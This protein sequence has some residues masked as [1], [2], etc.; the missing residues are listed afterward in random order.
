MCGEEKGS[1]DLARGKRLHV[2]VAIVYNKGV[3]LCESYDKMNGKFFASFIRQHFN[4]CFWRA[5]PQRDGKRLFVMDSD[6]SQTSKVAKNA[7]KDIE[8]ELLRIPRSSPDINPIENIFHIVKNLLE[9]E[10]IEENLT[11]ET[12]EEFK[13]RVLR[14]IKNVDPAIIDK[15]IESM[16]Q[17]VRLIIKGKGYR[18]KN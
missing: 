4:L 6:P 14:T 15:A 11:C 17:R 2:M 16:P 1:K 18:T 9:C 7:L 10:A 5:G 12:F 3:I 8:C 13:T